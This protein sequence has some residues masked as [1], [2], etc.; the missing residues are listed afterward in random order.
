MLHSVCQQIWK[1]QQWPQDWKRSVFISIP[2]KGKAKECSLYCMIALISHAGKVMFKNLFISH[3]ILHWSRANSLEKTLM[4]GKIQGRRRRGWKRIRRLD[5][6]ITSMDMSLSKLW[7]LVMDREAWCIAVHEVAKSQTR[8]GDWI[9]WPLVYISWG[10]Y[11]CWTF[12]L[13][14]AQCESLFTLCVTL[15]VIPV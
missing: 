8:L 3:F 5:G 14:M 2:K 7:E 12:A 9:D 1:T 10:F 13:W 11:C 4:L 6:I 15:D